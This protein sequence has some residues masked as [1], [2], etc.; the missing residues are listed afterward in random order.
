LAKGFLPDEA[1]A[2]R[3][4]V[5]SNL[6]VKVVDNSELFISAS[7]DDESRRLNS[8]QR[9]VPPHL[10]DAELFI[11]L[12]K[13]Q[14]WE[15][16]TSRRNFEMPYLLVCAADQVWLERQ[17]AESQVLVE[18]LSQ[19]RLS[20][21][22]MIVVWKSFSPSFKRKLLFVLQKL[23]VYKHLFRVATGYRPGA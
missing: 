7:I 9:D 12:A 10:L 23:G 16:S 13:H 22:P 3:P 18:R 5:E 6:D 19:R 20:L 17:T 8:P 1:A 15:S 21:N 11:T 2:L 14:R 4:L